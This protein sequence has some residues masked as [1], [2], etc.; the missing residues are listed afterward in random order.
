MKYARWVSDPKK[1]PLLLS[2]NPIGLQFPD[3]ADGL[4]FKY[5]LG[6]CIIYNFIPR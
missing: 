1:S 5:V 2:M 6:N 4:H 3:C